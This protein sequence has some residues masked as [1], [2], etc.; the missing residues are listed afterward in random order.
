MEIRF[1]KPAQLW[2]THEILSYYHQ[3]NKPII[4]FAATYITL[5][6]QLGIFV[7][8]VKQNKFYCYNHVNFF[9]IS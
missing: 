6:F 8:H 4:L 3:V 1:G 5:K 2:R 9:R 7:L